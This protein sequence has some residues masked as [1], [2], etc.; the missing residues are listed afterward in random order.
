M[1]TPSPSTLTPKLVV[2]DADRAIDFYTRVFG[3]EE[4]ERMQD[5]GRVLHSVLSL[6]GAHLG[7]VDARP[8][9]GNTAPGADSAVILQLEVDDPD[10]L[11]ARAEQHGA[12]IVF[13]AADRPYGRRDTRIRDPFGHLWILGRAL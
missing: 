6:R 3:A 9:S 8:G 2:E 10:A 4:L 1:T 12:T 7:V 13:P 5:G 11:A